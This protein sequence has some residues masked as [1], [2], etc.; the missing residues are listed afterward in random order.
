MVGQHKYYTARINIDICGLFVSTGSLLCFVE[1]TTLQPQN[2]SLSVGAVNTN[3]WN[4][5]SSF[6]PSWFLHIL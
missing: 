1:Q 6:L 3:Q 4:V 2:H 5:L